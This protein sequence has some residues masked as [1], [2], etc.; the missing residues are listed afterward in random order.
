MSAAA[1]RM[2]GTAAH[3]G[4]SARLAR[5]QDPERKIAAAEA[6]NAELEG[7]RTMVEFGQ[8][9][10]VDAA[11]HYQHAVA[12][13][14]WADEHQ[15]VDVAGQAGPPPASSAGRRP[16]RRRPSTSAGAQN[17]RQGASAPSAGGGR[18]G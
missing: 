12:K 16:R 2:T 13:I 14:P 8:V 5:S 3:S 6:A 18:R 7:L 4:R 9:A 10:V 11:E 15:P 17:S 1:G